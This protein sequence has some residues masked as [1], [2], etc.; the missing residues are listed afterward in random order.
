MKIRLGKAADEGVRL[1]REGYWDEG[2]FC[3]SHYVELEKNPRLRSRFYSYLGIAVALRQDRVQEGMAL[4]EKAMKLDG[5]DPENYLNM[6]KIQ[7]LTGHKRAVIKTL[8]EGLKLAP[9]HHSLN[10][11]RQRLGVRRRPVV[12]LL[13]RSNPLNVFL[14]NCAINSWPSPR[15][16]RKKRNP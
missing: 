8:D 1:C 10:E 15:N 6:A 12:P 4:C 13:S 5:S 7:L 16:G 14:E 2:L 3:M 11:L 9:K